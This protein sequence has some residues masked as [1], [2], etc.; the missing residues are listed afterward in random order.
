MN[1]R[2]TAPVAYITRLIKTTGKTEIKKIL[3]ESP[4]TD[5]EI[6][7]VLDYAN[8][9]TYKELSIKYNKSLQRINQWKHQIYC[10]LHFYLVR[11][12]T[13]NNEINEQ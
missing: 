9:A 5:Q 6:N 8:G 3:I 11:K 10:D 2:K 13:T 12:I 1:G 7:L 4:L